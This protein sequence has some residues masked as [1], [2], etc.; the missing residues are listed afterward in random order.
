MPQSE[1]MP[2]ANKSPSGVTVSPL[3][4]FFLRVDPGARSSAECTLNRIGVVHVDGRDRHPGV[5]ERLRAIV[6]V[7]QD[8]AEEIH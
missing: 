7:G 8:V 4:F 5:I 1:T 3:F 6:A 2:T